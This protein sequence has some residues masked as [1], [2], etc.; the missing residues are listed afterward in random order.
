LAVK[1]DYH[2]LEDF[3]ASKHLSVDAVLDDGWGALM[4][5]KGREVQATVLFADMAAFSSRTLDMSPVETLIFVQWF[6]AWV[7]AEAL[8]G[9]RGIIDKYIGD[10]V[11]IVFSEEFGSEDPFTEA[12]HTARWMA[13]RD[14]WSFCPHIGIASG[15]VI[16]GY[17]GTPSKYNCSVFGSPVAFAARCAGVSPATDEVYASSIVFPAAEW[18]ERDFEKVFPPH[19]YLRPDN[20]TAEQPHAW[21]MLRER[22]VPMKNMPPT[23][24][25][26][27]VKTSM[28]FS[29]TSAE[30][31]T[32]D[33]LGEIKAAGRYWPDA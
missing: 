31:A 19:E 16:V 25:R 4:P 2:S 23:C 9:G 1:Y 15:R 7:G 26:E 17:V 8:R 5:V 18:G 28:N 22:V 29:M 10:E 13:E 12:V 20:T 24:I 6:F 21:K 33:V 3:L 14:P 11:M 27:I 30:E 32:R